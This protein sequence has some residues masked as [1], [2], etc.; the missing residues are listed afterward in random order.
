MVF[1]IQDQLVVQIVQDVVAFREDHHVVP[2]VQFEQ[3]LEAG[4]IDQED[5]VS[6]GRDRFGDGEGAVL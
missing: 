6:R 3:F 4:L 5:G 1:E 2:I